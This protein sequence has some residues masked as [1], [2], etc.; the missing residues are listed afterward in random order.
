[1]YKDVRCQIE[2]CPYG[3]GNHRCCFG[4]LD[5]DHSGDITT[6]RQKCK[7]D[8]H[9]MVHVVIIRHNPGGSAA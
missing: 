4:E 6:L 3:M 5:L 9:R 2:K 1:M 7:K 8:G